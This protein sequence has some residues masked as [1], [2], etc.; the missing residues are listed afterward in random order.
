MVGRDWRFVKRRGHETTL[1]M[2]FE[3]SEIA[4]SALVEILDELP[5]FILID[6]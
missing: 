1:L 3:G 4:W 5:G 2:A 6:V